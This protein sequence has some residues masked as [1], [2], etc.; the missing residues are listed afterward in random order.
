MNETSATIWSGG[1]L[2][3]FYGARFDED[4]TLWMISDTEYGGE[5][6]K[7]IQGYHLLTTEGNTRSKGIQM[8]SLILK[9]AAEEQYTISLQQQV[10]PPYEGILPAAG[11]DLIPWSNGNFM[12]TW[13][14][15]G[16]LEEV[17]K[18]GRTSVDARKHPSREFGILWFDH[19]S[20]WR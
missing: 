7:E 1:E 10:P 4:G 11:G 16:V 3:T 6:S 20:I 19:N 9:I 14:F 15:S 2:P 8:M 5:K 13:G 17:N 18:R 12:V